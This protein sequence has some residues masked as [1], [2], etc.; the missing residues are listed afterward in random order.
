[1]VLACMLRGGGGVRGALPAVRFPGPHCVHAPVPWMD[2]GMRTAQTAKAVA[3]RTFIHIMQGHT[4]QHTSFPRICR[5][6]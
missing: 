5:P 2:W 6:T 3:R 4:F 1:M